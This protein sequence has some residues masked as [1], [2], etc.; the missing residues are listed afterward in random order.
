MR[1]GA[2]NQNDLL[3]AYSSV[4]QQPRPCMIPEQIGVAHIGLQH[5]HAFVSR[6]IPHLEHRSA[7]AGVGCRSKPVP[8]SMGGA[9]GGGRSRRHV[10]FYPL[11]GARSD[12]ERRRDLADPPALPFFSAFRIAASVAALMVGRPSV[13]P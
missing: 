11:H 12:P 9:F 10:R 4:L 3:P 2:V 5:I 8:R 13:L 1:R 7:A 6:H